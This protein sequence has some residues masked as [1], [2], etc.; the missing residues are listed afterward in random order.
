MNTQF[1]Q[2]VILKRSPLWSRAVVWGLVGVTSFSVIWASLARIDE[3]V[4]ATG[5]LEPQGTVRDI[6]VPLNGVVKE[7]LVKDGDSVKQGQV[8]ITLDRVADA[9][10]LESLQ[11]IRAALVTENAFYQSELQEPGS[12]SRDLATLRLAPEMAALTKSRAA[13]VDEIRLFQAQLQ[14][15]SRGVTLSP[16]QQVRLQSTLTEMDSRKQAAQLEVNQ[17]ERQLAQTRVQLSSSQANLKVTQSIFKDM[18]TVAREGGIARVQYL[19]QQQQVINSQARVDQLVQEEERLQYAIA[20][21]QQR[22][23]NTVS[24]SQQDLL[25]KIADNQKKIAEIDGQLNKAIVENK[26]KIAEVDSQLSQAQTALR[27]RELR[28]PTDGVVFDLKVS[29]GYVATPN[30][31]DPVL[32]VVPEEALVVKAYIP[33]KDIGFVKEGMPSDIRIDAFPFSEF[34]DVKGVVSSIGSDALPPT[35]IRPFY[36]FPV[37]IKPDRQFLSVRGREVPLQSGMAVSANIKVRQRSVLSLFT[38]G[39]IRQVDRLQNVR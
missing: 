36:S 13:L 28:A 3:A 4:S 31:T 19:Q 11:K 7:V 24:L 5:K 26:K 18:E 22:L 14:G 25:N 15:S 16:E 6:Q 37:T 23:Q 17:L 27:Y 29:P 35:Q 39:F 9:V 2:S 1:D 21:A 20:Q 10:Q 34:G 8:L 12:R 38:D 32:K 33:N 30:A